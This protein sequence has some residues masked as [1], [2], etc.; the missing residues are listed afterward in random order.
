MSA[1]LW[2]PSPERV[3]S[4]RMA[5]F[6]QRLRDQY[7]QRFPDYWNLWRW[8]IANKEY[9]W[10]ELWDFCGV[11][12]EQGERTLI[13]G[14][15]MPGAAWFPDAR[16]NFA[17]NLLRKRGTEDALVFWNEQGE[18]RRCSFDA[19]RHEVARAQRALR[20]AGVQAGD[21]VA[22]M[23][24]NIPEAAIAMLGATSLGAT[25]S[26]SSPDFGVQGVLDRFAQIAPKVLFA[27]NG[28]FYNGKFIDTRDKGREIA[29]RLP[30]VERVVWVEYIADHPVDGGAGNQPW[31]QFVANDAV[32]PTF[33]RFPFDH[34]LVIV[35]SSGTTGLPKCMVHGAGG[36]L[37]QHVKEHALHS[38][39]RDGDRVFYF[40][41]TGWV[42]WNWLISG[43]ATGATCMLYDGSPFANGGRVLWDYAE[44]ERFTL[45]GTSAKYIDAIKKAGVVP[46]RSHAL[47]ALRA[48]LSTGSP[49]LPESFDYVY[50]C[51][52][53]DVHLASISG[54]TDIM[55]CFA[56][57][58]PMLPVYRGELQCRGLGMATDV[59][60]DGGHSR[61]GEMGELVCTQT[62]PSM[63]LYFMNDPDGAR[64]RASYFERFPGLWCHGD[65][66]QITEHDGMVIVGRSDATLNPGGVR[67]GTAEIYRQVETLPEVVESIVIGQIFHGDTRVVLFVKLA[68]GL[69]LD[70]ALIAKIKERIRDNTTPRHVPAR[71]VQVP[72]IPRTKSNK[73]V[74]LAV[75]D[76]VHGRNVKNV[77]AL[78]NPEALEHFR[79]RVELAS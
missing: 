18:R 32:E 25:W 71:V 22:S 41:T 46:R 70:A 74:E 52:K 15:L 48:V 42:M 75:R 4:T 66:C 44:S 3:A 28:Y 53:P 17:E 36:T 63:P 37:L 5:A 54:G 9:F 62:F 56:A 76:V 45:F 19:L 68:E 73:I 8:S 23:L 13:D 14:H 47:P 33:E 38:D 69:R 60:D 35:Y 34:P 39:V 26:S 57:G 2:T 67:I 12:G 29:A 58:N 40:S 78:A 59:F 20:E 64:Y 21:R 72:D 31:T 49:L 43:L 24:P 30:S 55:A 1:P 61:V 79:N 11:V 65:W 16:L 10:R 6:T 50:Q 77:D 27:V 51:V 7:G